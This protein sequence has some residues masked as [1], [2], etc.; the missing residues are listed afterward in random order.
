MY[1]YTVTRGISC[2]SHYLMVAMTTRIR[3]DEQSPQSLFCAFFSSNEASMSCQQNRMDLSN[4]WLVLASAVR[5]CTEQ[6]LNCCPTF[7]RVWRD[8]FNRR[9]WLEWPVLHSIFIQVCGYCNRI[10]LNRSESVATMFVSSCAE[11]SNI[12]STLTHN[13]TNSVTPTKGRIQ[14][15][16]EVTEQQLNRTGIPHGADWHCDRQPQIPEPPKIKDHFNTSPARAPAPVSLPSRPPHNQEETNCI[17]Q[18]YAN[19]CRRKPRAWEK[20]HVIC[21]PD[22][23]PMRGTRQLMEVNV[24]VDEMQSLWPFSPGTS[25]G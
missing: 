4:I 14:A 2:C 15:Q 17:A 1:T 20:G 8:N 10:D 23:Q 11:V 5:L 12:T 13:N 22:M 7:L 25:S 6:R 18:I 21:L 16:T 19:Y 9:K 24:R 3:A